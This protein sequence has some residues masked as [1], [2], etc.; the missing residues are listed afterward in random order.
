[1]SVERYFILYL[2]LDMSPEDT[3]Q[4]GNTKV[5]LE[6]SLFLFFI[7]HYR[8]FGM[9]VVADDCRSTIA[10][11]AVVTKRLKHSHSVSA[12]K[13]ASPHYHLTAR[14]LLVLYQLR[15]GPLLPQLEPKLVVPLPEMWFIEPLPEPHLTGP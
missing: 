5:I 6:K 9:E 14:D 7:K 12:Q 1:M 15:S 4:K 8:V 11:W 3:S 2:I 10:S 13:S